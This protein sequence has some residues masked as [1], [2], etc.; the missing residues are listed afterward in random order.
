MPGMLRTPSKCMM[1]VM[2]QSFDST[3]SNSLRSDTGWGPALTARLAFHSCTFSMM[4][5][6]SLVSS[7]AVS[8][9]IGALIPSCMSRLPKACRPCSTTALAFS[10]GS[11]EEMY[12]LTA[13]RI[14]SWSPPTISTSSKHCLNF[15]LS[16]F[17]PAPSRYSPSASS[18]ASLCCVGLLAPFVSSVDPCATMW[19]ES[20]ARSPDA[21]SIKRL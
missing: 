8:A 5:V 3:S 9:L 20:F 15:S 1:T 4:V 16:T 12:L 17:N 7:T 10:I 2:L 6:G 11:L 18:N 21:G 19:T 13:P 14:P